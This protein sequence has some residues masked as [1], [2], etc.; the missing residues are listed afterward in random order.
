[1]KF[2]LPLCF[3]TIL[4]LSSCTQ[5]SDDKA[6]TTLYF[7]RH[8]EK[9]RSNSENKNPHLTETGLAR[10]AYWADVFQSVK[11]DAIYT[12]NYKRTI[13][14]GLPTA[15]NNNLEIQFYD[16][17]LLDADKML[18][19]NKGNN[20]LIVGHSD[21]TPKF[22]NKFLGIESYQEIDDSNNSNLYIITISDNLVTD[23]L[24]TLNP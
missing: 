17:D 1:M 13:E 19:E 7:I 20:V 8:A 6:L 15:Q 12:T 9:D 14:T 22:V 2:L 21:T 23:L 16:G 24:L 3:I 18:K 11:F 10:A 5:K 4:G